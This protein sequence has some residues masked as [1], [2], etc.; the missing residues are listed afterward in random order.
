[1]SLGGGLYGVANRYFETSFSRPP[2]LARPSGQAVHAWL[3]WA[4]ASYFMM[5]YGPRSEAWVITPAELFGAGPMYLSVAEPKHE[6]G[7]AM[8][9]WVRMQQDDEDG[10]DDSFEE[11][12]EAEGTEAGD[13]EQ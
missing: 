12:E 11:E 2:T 6:W 4:L 10:F 1:L 5:F 3:Q 8:A 9:E 7:E 13:L